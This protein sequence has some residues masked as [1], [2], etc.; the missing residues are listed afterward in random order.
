ASPPGP[1]P[2]PVGD[3]VWIRDIQFPARRRPPAKVTGHS[4]KTNRDRIASTS[5]TE[6][7]DQPNG[8]GR[9]P[10]SQYSGQAMI[11]LLMVV[12]K[13]E[14]GEKREEF[15]FRCLAMLGGGRTSYPR[16]MVCTSSGGM[17]KTLA[18]SRRQSPLVVRSVQ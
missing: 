8:P 9:P 4:G 11:K 14:E 1:S 2:S 15:G 6:A 16:G 12:N 7:T 5:A 13:K 17:V 10:P 3:A 18:L